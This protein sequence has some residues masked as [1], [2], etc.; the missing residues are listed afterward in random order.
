MVGIGRREFITL[1]GGAPAVWPLAAKAQQ[2]AMPV[3]GY[4]YVGS[5]EPT[6]HL[7]A[8]F[9]KGL[10]QTGFVEGRDVAIEY[11]W[12]DSE[13]NRLRES[14]ADLVR[15]RVT[16]M[17][18]PNGL[19]ALAAKAATR[20]I[21]I[22]FYTGADPVRAGL[23]ASLDR[24][25]G[26]A[27]GISSM[28]TELGGKRLGLLYEMLR[29]RAERFGL[30]TQSASVRAELRAAAAA[31]ERPL[32]VFTAGNSRE[33]DAAFSS[34]AQKRVDGLLVDANIPFINNRVQISTLAAHHRLPAIYP[35]R[36]SA[37]AGGL[38][39]Y[40]TS[41]P[42]LFRQVGIYTGRILKGEKPAEL[43]VLQPTKS[44]L[45]INLPTAR[46]LG[47]EVP[48]TLLAIADQVIE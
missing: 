20:T 44:E 42:D 28:N 45:V 41:L 25:G 46:A 17:A 27:T 48:P 30:L 6:S 43:P 18:I 29:Q 5:P 33:I 26:N 19:A 16:V 37:E 11:R 23:V 9:R 8:A 7:V 4:L 35:W 24:P 36:E 39:S 22:I 31:I 15:S 47:I 32:D 40:G 34:M 3:V 38:M 21:P 10:G 1:L 13:F 12:A 2:R 14:A